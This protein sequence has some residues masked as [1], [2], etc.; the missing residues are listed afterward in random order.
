MGEKDAAC[1]KE[2]GGMGGATLKT[3]KTIVA[4]KKCVYIR[5]CKGL[6]Q[7]GGKKDDGSGSLGSKRGRRMVR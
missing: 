4:L 3:D 7:S 1:R 6:T 5:S 2:L